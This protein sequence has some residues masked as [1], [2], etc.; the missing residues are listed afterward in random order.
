M[1]HKKQLTPLGAVP[2]LFEGVAD[3]I[4][5]RILSNAYRKYTSVMRVPAPE[6]V[7]NS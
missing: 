7:L 4:C 5:E 3:K 6:R 1:P 2:D